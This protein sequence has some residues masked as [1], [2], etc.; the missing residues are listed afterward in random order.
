MN[1]PKQTQKRLLHF[2][3]QA[4]KT[5]CKKPLIYKD[6]KCYGLLNRNDLT[7]KLL[8]IDM[9]SRIEDFYLTTWARGKTVMVG[10]VS[11]NIQNKNCTCLI[12]TSL[13]QQ[14]IQR[15]QVNNCSCKDI[16]YYLT[17]S[18]PT[19]ISPVEKSISYFNV[20][21]EHTP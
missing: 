7:N 15:W 19:V 1:I 11:H 21:M 10:T 3:V 9:S 5:S 16:Q 13:P 17:M 20:V 14:E 18:Q 12:T 6:N 2:K 4:L 8:L